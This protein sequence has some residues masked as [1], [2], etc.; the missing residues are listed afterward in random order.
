[1]E[2]PNKEIAFNISWDENHNYFN[3]SVGGS[4]FNDNFFFIGNGLNGFRVWKQCF[5]HVSYL[6]L[7]QDPV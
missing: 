5:L 1:M 7:G 3:F 4:L 6:V 2:V